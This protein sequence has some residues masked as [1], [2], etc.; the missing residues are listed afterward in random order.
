MP[1]SLEMSKNITQQRNVDNMQTK[2][3]QIEHSFVYF[4]NRSKIPLQ[5][6]FTLIEFVNSKPYRLT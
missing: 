1:F 4:T 2:I 3:A 5:M 6:L